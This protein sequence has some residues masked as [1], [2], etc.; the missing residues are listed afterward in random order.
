MR[1][2]FDKR[3]PSEITIRNWFSNADLNCSPGIIEY[4][5]NVLK[6]KAEEIAGNN[7]KLI[8]V[9]IYDEMSIHK[10]LQFINNEMIGYENVPSIDLKDAKLASEGLVFLFN[11]INVNLKLPVAYYFIN[12][13]DADKKSVLVQNIIRRLINIGIDL[14]SLTFDGAK[15]NPTLCQILGANLDVFSES[16]HPSITCDDHQV[17]VLY[18]PS[19]D[20]K[21]V[22]GTLA[23]KGTIYEPD[24]QTIKWKF[25]EQLV[26]YK[27]QRNFGE[28]IHKMTQAH[29]N[30]KS[31]PMKVKLAVETLSGSTANAMEYLMNQGFSHF[32]NAD[33]TIRSDISD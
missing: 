29:I 9:L 25:F 20:I 5:L 16:F 28:S 12:K 1:N 23:I 6:R 10:L 8:G 26:Q 31:D 3:I 24:G 32:Q 18:D 4:S 27:Q 19:H 15:E 33:A 30:W 2:E 13:L 17:N 22:R 11:G 14:T 21:L 7:E